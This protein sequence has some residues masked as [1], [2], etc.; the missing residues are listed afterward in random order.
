ML[1]LNASYSKKVP[2]QEKFSSESY[3]ACIEVELP[4]GQTAQQ[5]QDKIHETFELVKASVESEIAGHLTPNNSVHKPVQR[6]LSDRTPPARESAYRSFRLPA[7]ACPRAPRENKNHSGGRTSTSVAVKCLWQGDQLCTAGKLS[8]SISNT[9]RW[10]STTTSVRTPSAPRLSA[11]RIFRFLGARKPDRPVRSS[12]ASSRPAG[13][14][15]STRRTT[16][17]RCLKRCRR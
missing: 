14:S 15:A 7:G 12:T 11:K 5:L 6:P 9:A 2:T 3:L 4:T 17:A 8:A 1:K 13:K 16:Y 10:R